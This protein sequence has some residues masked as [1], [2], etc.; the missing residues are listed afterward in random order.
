[1]INKTQHQ[2]Q[3]VI[4]ELL[5]LSY[6]EQDVNVVLKKSLVII[7]NLSNSLS[8]SNKGLIFIVNENSKLE[9]VAKQN[10]SKKIFESCQL[11][12]IGNCYCDCGK[13]ALTKEA[14]FA[15]YLDYTEEENERMVCKENHCSIPILYK[16]NVYGVLMLF[17]ERN[18]QK[19]ESKIQLFTTLANT[20]GLILYK[21]KLE[22]YTSYI[23]TSLDI[24]IGNE[25][26]IEIAKFLSKELGMKHCLIGQFEH[27]KDD[28]FVK[29]IV[30]SS[31]QKINKN[32]T[33]NLLNTPC[34]L[35]L[36]D[37]ISFY[38]NN[39]Q[40]LF[41]LDEYL[42]KLNIESYFGLV[43]RN[44]D[45]TP[46]GIL[47]FMHDAPASN[48][49]EKK[50]IIDVFLPRLVSEIERRSK[51]DELIA[52]K[53]KY[54]NLFNTFQD[55]FLRTSI[56]ENYESIIEEI[57][58]SI[59]D[60]SGY[61]PKELIGKSTSIFY[62]DIEQRED[63]FKKLMKAKKVIDYP[64]T[65]IKK[66]GKLIH[67][68]ANVQLFFDE[69]DNPYEI[70]AVFRDVTEKRKE[71]LRKDI[72]YTIAKKAQR[73]LANF[74]SISEY[75]YK[76]LGS[77]IDTSNF[78]ISLVD[79]EKK[80]I[81]FP[82]FA[83][84]LIKPISK[85]NYSRIFSN[86]LL[87][88]II[89]TKNMFIKT[90][91]E[92]KEIIKENKIDYKNKLPKIMVSF[93]L[94]SEGLIV[95][96]VTTKSYKEADAFSESDIN[97]LEFIATQ[98]SNVIERDQ[99]Q[100]NLIAKEKYFRSLV[101]SSLEVILI[102]NDSGVIQ[103]VSESVEAIFGYKPYELIGKNILTIVPGYLKIEVFANF[104]QLI[105]EKNPKNPYFTKIVA[106]NEKYI[107][108]QFS[109]NNQLKNKYIEGLIINAQDI[110]TQYYNNKILEESQNKLIEEEK[111]YRTIFNN[112]ND[113]IVRF[114]K[115]FKIIDANKRMTSII[116]YTKKELLT[117][118]IFDLATPA[119]VEE[120]TTEV[121]KLILKE[122]KSLVLEK[123]SIHKNGNSVSCKVFMKSIFKA[124]Q[125]LD[126]II[127]FITDITKRNEAILKAM[128][129]EK[130][131]HY[132]TNVLY[133]DINGVIL[134]ANEKLLKNSG[135]SNEE[136]IG[137]H[138]RMFNSNYH[139]KSFFK[140]IWDTI[141][142]GNVWSGEIR[143]KKKNG[144]FYWVFSTMIP[145][146][147][148]NNEVSYFIDVKYDITE[149][150]RSRANRIRD[151]ID[152]QEK[153]KENFAK[154][155]HDGL[156]QILLASKMNLNSIKDTV[157]ELDDQTKDV[158]DN[159]LSLLNLSIQEARNI[160]HG[161]MSRVLTQFGLAHAIQDMVT[162]LQLSTDN[163]AF[164]FSHSLEKIRFKG[165]IEKGLYRVTQELISNTIKHSKASCVVIEMYEKDNLLIIKV[166]D[167][168]IGL[169]DVLNGKKLVQGIG[170]KNIETRITYLSG[171]FIINDKIEKGSEFLISVPINN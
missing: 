114:D 165:E 74:N 90:E 146:K 112:A 121:N 75:V 113:G 35:L 150:K 120:I 52:E 17:F 161:L 86:G 170:L 1:M 39:I 49:K 5:E 116:G 76:A 71:E 171:S 68:L 82:V 50:E 125:T 138:T 16:E 15:S 130:A 111:N 142:S 85:N 107:Y 4:N 136:V 152:A 143:N 115:D 147:D 8:F 65:L 53:K 69:D 41:P 88:Y 134:Y 28:N 77:I 36:A 117:K 105:K 87:E 79:A 148:L 48:F 122:K 62:Y 160:S 104:M 149:L 141:L 22:K 166:K 11:V 33:Y 97:L 167:D 66:N 99:W 3:L 124:D 135:Y 37:D 47:V 83:D 59:Y 6:N 9:L 163:I 92:L 145:M 109:V 51:E 21:K 131:L 46:L 140:Q 103:Y 58:P 154:E 57:S 10:I 106:K 151:V 110:T 155:V 43:L 73:R 128:E 123:N 126:Y 108:V 67:T 72:S 56:N 119:S 78:N 168:G 96:T 80:C 102:T 34:D 164:N 94:K 133:T 64:I 153:E 12:E 44:R 60:F 55:V 91:D 139:P 61:K 38:P 18:S 26:F 45:F 14:Q 81:E 70:V 101:E 100:K 127:A 30:F 7:L 25:Y 169:S 137:Q 32:I 93:P 23:K 156:G 2:L 95:G 13:A 144:N 132:S 31:N 98:L 118:T 19:S 158:Y 159:S 162:N 63:L 27:K 89:K 29:T 54:K 24:R 84:E 129:I 157:Y 20:L 42:K 40:Q